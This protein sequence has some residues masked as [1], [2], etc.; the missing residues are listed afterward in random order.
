MGSIAPAVTVVSEDSLLLQQIAWSLDG[1]GYVV[2][3]CQRFETLA[4]CWSTATPEFLL[5]DYDHSDLAVASKLPHLTDHG[6][7]YKILLA[8]LGTS[9]E[10]VAELEL[11]FN[12][13]V[14]KPVRVG[15]LLARL[16]AGAEYSRYERRLRDAA[17]CDPC[18]GL[19][20]LQG[21]THTLRSADVADVPLGMIVLEIDYLESLDRRFGAGGCDSLLCAAAERIEAALPAEAWLARS[22]PGTFAVVWVDA[23]ETELQLTADEIRRR[24]D[25]SKFEIRGEVVRLT[26]T[27]V[28]DASTAGVDGLSDALADAQRS[29]Q[30]ARTLG[31]GT[32]S[33][34]RQIQETYAEYVAA[35]LDGVPGQEATARDLMAPFAVA[36][37]MGHNRDAAWQALGR[38]TASVAPVNDQAGQ[39]AGVVT[40]NVWQQGVE[41]GWEAEI[42]TPQEVDDRTGRSELL[43]AF[44]ADE[45]ELLVVMSDG[46]PV[47]YLVRESLEVVASGS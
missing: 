39:Y 45:C 41:V 16:A 42:Q 27:L 24:L 43:D 36:I 21:L 46:K 8:S 10:R 34:G 6:F 14:A 25:T 37:E 23:R 5:V 47:G 44:S 33:E 13:V 4:T 9:L 31:G 30:L 2:Q 35:N 1:A 29:L 18:T 22:G 32:V 38:S 28:I 12:D 11:S 19:L 3:P 17:L 20:S 26:A 40:S 15:E 7:C